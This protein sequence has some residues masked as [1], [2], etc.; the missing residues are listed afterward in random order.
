M[1]RFKFK[2][3][4]AKS[5]QRRLTGEVQDPYIK[6]DVRLF[7]PADGPN[8][9]RMMPPTW[10][11]ADH[12]GIDIY[13]HYGLGPDNRLAYLCPQ[14]MKMEPCPICEER[15]KAD[16][17]GDEEYAR[18]LFPTRRV[19]AYVVD[20]KKTEDGVKAWPM[21]YKK[22]DQAIVLQSTDPE[23]QE[24]FP[25]DDPEDGFNIVVTKQGSGLTTDYSVSIARHATAFKF[26]SA[27]EEFI[28]ENPLPASLN[29]YDYD[30]IAKAFG[31]G[32]RGR[33]S[34]TSHSKPQTEEKPQQERKKA[35]T[36]DVPESYKELSELESE[37]LD[38]LAAEHT[39]LDLSVFS[40]DQEVIDA[41]AE[42]LEIQKPKR[43]RRAVKKDEPETET[44][45]EEGNEDNKQE[46]EEEAP[47]K[48]GGFKERMARLK[49]SRGE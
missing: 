20:T 21:P 32:S 11:D 39:D 34:S 25:V 46:E 49:K 47:S 22:V 19:L 42:E 8:H 9:L 18:S 29:F 13:V 3:R 33:S 10:D 23:T 44:E 37:D 30:H 38:K 6:S 1:A 35:P 16:D 2:K 12:Y 24:Y 7:R 48:A 43:A 40:S 17:E 27:I 14:R 36:I 4:D 31:G 15:A 26:T 45:S 5:A 28:V 41:L